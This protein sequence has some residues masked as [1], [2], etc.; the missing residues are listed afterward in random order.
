VQVVDPLEHRGDLAKAALR[1]ICSSAVGSAAADRPGRRRPAARAPAGRRGDRFARQHR[2]AVAARLLVEADLVAPQALAAVRQVDA[3]ADLEVLPGA[4]Q[5]IFETR[6]APRRPLQPLPGAASSRRKRNASRKFDL[7]DAFGPPEHALAEAGQA[8]RKFFQLC[9]SMS[10]IRIPASRAPHPMVPIYIPEAGLDLMR[11]GGA[12]VGCAGRLLRSA[13]G[14][15][16]MWDQGAGPP[17][18]GPDRS[19]ALRANGRH[20]GPWH[21]RGACWRVMDRRWYLPLR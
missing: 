18:L 21:R 5:R 13:P 3:E 15:I 19:L 16:G 7:P 4:R 11:A 2:E 8:C 12:D 9:S 1:W 17:A 10:L 20:P 14:R 6:R